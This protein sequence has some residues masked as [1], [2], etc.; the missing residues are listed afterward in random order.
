M[1]EI[2]IGETKI[3]KAD[4]LCFALGNREIYDAHISKFES[5][6]SEYGFLDALKVIPS[7]DCFLIVEGQHRFEAGKRLGM[8]K[9]P[10]YVIDWLEGCDEDEIQNIIISLNANNKTWTIYDYV[11]SFADRGDEDYKILKARMIQYRETLS[12]GVVASCHSGA[13]RSHTTIKDGNF[14]NLNNQFSEW[15]LNRLHQ[16]VISDGKKNFPSRTLSIFVNNI[17]QYR[18]DMRLIHMIIQEMRKL[19]AF[20]QPLPDGDQAFGQWFDKIVILIGEEQ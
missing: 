10:C 11:K 17:W 7:D 15:L 5:L 16:A 14:K 18:D 6:L 12:N 19:I 9:F 4:N 2:K 1:N 13:A 8:K 20:G 3:I